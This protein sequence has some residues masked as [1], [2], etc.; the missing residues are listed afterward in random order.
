MR[1]IIA[2][3]ILLL[4]VFLSLAASSVFSQPREITKAE[5]EATERAA[6]SKLQGA[7]YRMRTTWSSSKAAI[8]S[9]HGSLTSSVSECAPQDRR[10]TVL[11]WQTAKGP[12]T[13]ETISI[14][15]EEVVRTNDGPWGKR[16]EFDRFTMIGGSP[17]KQT[18]SA[19][20]RYIGSESIRGVDAEVY[21]ENMYREFDY[22]DHTSSYSSLKRI[23]VTKDGRLV[24]TEEKFG[25]SR[26]TVTS[27]SYSDYE[28]DETIKIEAP[29]I[30][31]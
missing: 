10:R 7:T 4:G 18:E 5:F 31:K 25:G 13:E 27:S 20:Y 23:W 14:D 15:G 6:R 11:T 29:S 17:P 21:E 9:E 8:E 2:N 24:R 19:T 16:K 28:Y 26:G 3:S 22:G 1:T 12:R 30:K